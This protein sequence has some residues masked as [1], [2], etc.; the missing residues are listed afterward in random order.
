LTPTAAGTAN[1]V[2]AGVQQA[3]ATNKLAV[4]GG[5][6]HIFGGKKITY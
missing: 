6:T 3:S 2:C 5:K 1:I 4:T